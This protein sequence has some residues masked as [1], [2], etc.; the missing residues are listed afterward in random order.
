VRHVINDINHGCDMRSASTPIR[1]LRFRYLADRFRRA[2]W[3]IAAWESDTNASLPTF[4]GPLTPPRD[5]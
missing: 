5:R 2:A 4:A 3:T 1:R